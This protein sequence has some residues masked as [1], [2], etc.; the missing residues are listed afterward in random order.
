M[1]SIISCSVGGGIGTG[2]R[3][4]DLG[5]TDAVIGASM[6]FIETPKVVSVQYSVETYLH[7]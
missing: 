4:T 1:Q 6:N 2:G 3:P 7:L 5:V